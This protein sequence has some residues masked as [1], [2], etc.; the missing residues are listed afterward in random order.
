M[1]KKYHSMKQKII[2]YVMAVA[3]SLAVV[4]SLIMSIGNI[5]S[6]NTTLLDNM[7]TT[8]RIASQSI[9]SNLHLLTE[10]MY[11]LSRETVFTD[12]AS[13]DSDKLA[14]LS[15]AKLQIEFVWL[16]AYD[17]EGA[18]Q[19]GDEK[20]PASIAGEAYFAHLAQTGN[21][22][23]SDPYEAD[24][25]LQLCVG[26]PYT[27][28]DETAGYL[29]GSYKYDIL[30]DVLSMLIVG[31]TGSA[32]IVNEDGVIVGDRDTSAIGSRSNIYDDSS[33]AAAKNT[34]DKMLS[35][36]TGS[37]LIRFQ[38]RKCYAGYAPIPG[39]NWALLIYAPQAEFM[40][41]ALFSIVL[42]I[43]ISVILLGIAAVW[44]TVV[45]QKISVS[46][47]SATSRLQQLSDGNLTDAVVPS[48][49]NDETAVLT[50]AL[51]KTIASLNAY[52][53][54]I[55]TCLGALADGDY[56]IDIPDSFDGD[57]S[58]IQHSLNHIQES[59]NQ[60]MA[61]MNQSSEQ[62]N[63]N[64]MEVSNY[65]RQLQDA[66]LQQAN[67]LRQ[68]EESTASITSA[69]EKN[70]EQVLQMESCSENAGEKTRIGGTS[71]QSL[72][73]LMSDIQGS[74]EEI[75]K[76]SKLIND[77]SFQTNL[78]SLNASIEAARA[79]EAGRGFAVVA[80]QIS[81]LSAKTSEALQQTD[82]IIE[83]SADM[84]QKGVKAANETAAAF[85][86]IQEVAKQYREISVQLSG[87]AEEQ[88]LAVSCAT[89]QLDS[90][91][92]I[93]D[94]NHRLAEE[95][96]KMAASS[97]EQSESLHQLVSNVKLKSSRHRL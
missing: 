74:V 32:C 63:Q 40:D 76:I 56:T 53:Q 34:F 51:A 52:I 26:I 81:Q 29:V 80:A 12:A 65:A 49:S 87:T 36:Q 85:H 16:S 37:G 24:G 18:K 75:S 15:D 33:T 27:A 68:L 86:D 57:F 89:G 28:G 19:F 64:S 46:L 93:A 1:K 4:I 25:V 95:T 2:F 69:I 70:K 30:N 38:G 79:G 78:L 77:I 5:R 71:M 8:A 67:L 17:L 91:R 39:T 42:T 66:S 61:R 54:N 11:N 21:T 45:S 50:D 31:S 84:I 58:S 92:E 23:I 10:R 41:T 88:A 7:Q 73:E 55:R 48:E 97:L 90:I 14:C 82:A 44:I 6:T 43:C 47:A 20:A 3:V 60:S 96:N 13:S 35:Y 9:S 94:E 22:V 72:L 83:Q 62:V 59:L